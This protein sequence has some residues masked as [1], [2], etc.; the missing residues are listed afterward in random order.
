MSDDNTFHVLPKRWRRKKV[1]TSEEFTSDQRSKLEAAQRADR[2]LL[3][4]GCSKWRSW[5]EIEINWDWY[6]V[7]PVGL[8]YMFVRRFVCKRCGN[9]LKEDEL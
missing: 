2:G 4:R 3:C 9:T 1:H 7:P 5:S 8:T 6:I